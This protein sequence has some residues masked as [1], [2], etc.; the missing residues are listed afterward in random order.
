[1]DRLA[2]FRIGIAIIVLISAALPGTVT[3]STGSC[4]AYASHAPIRIDSDADFS[5]QSWP[6]SGTSNDPWVIGDIEINGT[7]GGYGIFIGNTT[8]HFVVED[9]EIHGG[10]RKFSYP[11]DSYSSGILLCNVTNGKILNS[12]VRFNYNGIYLLSANNI[13]IISNRIIN[14]TNVG[15]YLDYSSNNVIYRNSIVDNKKYDAC[16]EPTNAQYNNSWDGG[17]PAGGNYWTPINYTPIDYYSGT[18]QDIWGADGFIEYP[19]YRISHHS[20]DRYPRLFPPGYT[21]SSPPTSEVLLYGPYGQNTAPLAITIDPTDPDTGGL[22]TGIAVVR[23]WYRYSPDNITFNSWNEVTDEVI[24]PDNSSGFMVLPGWYWQFDYPSG[25]GYYEFTSAAI[26]VSANEE[27][28]LGIKASCAY[29]ITKP[30]S[31][32][33]EDLDAYQNVTIRLDGSASSDNLRIVNYTW[34]LTRNHTRVIQYGEN[35]E[36]T[37]YANASYL[38]TLCVTDIAGNQ[39]NDTMYVNVTM[40][41]A[42]LPPPSHWHQHLLIAAVIVCIALPLIWY[43]VKRRKKAVGFSPDG[44][45]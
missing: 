39:A 6:G 20:V 27:P 9:C 44:D 42:L 43:G 38:V 33:G 3:S 41:P 18:N 36:I 4:K 31:N 5:L 35:P 15:I 23:L 22:L 21:D 12:T 19:V 24:P 30:S 26:D 8:D 13:S 1:M 32:A 28:G 11:G 16:E 17:Y 7:G 25:E 34:S 37:F 14:N 10:E 40:D 29:D 45:R 2:E